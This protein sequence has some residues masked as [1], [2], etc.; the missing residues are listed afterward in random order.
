[1]SERCTCHNSLV[2]KNLNRWFKEKWVDVSR[3]DPKTGK[4]TVQY[5]DGEVLH[6]YF[7]ADG[8]LKDE[9]YR[10]RLLTAG[11]SERPSA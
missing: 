10:W 5:D 9:N 6:E 11:A 7:A 8:M 2:V 1:M 4:H 3:K